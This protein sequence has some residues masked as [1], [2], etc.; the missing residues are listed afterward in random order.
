[1]LQVGA[2]GINQPT[3]Q[4]TNQYPRNAEPLAD[5]AGLLGV[6]DA[7]RQSKEYIFGRTSKFV[8]VHPIKGLLARWSE[9][10]TR[11]REYMSI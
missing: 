11:K 6:W 4:P 8:P 9:I 5:A 1:M 3:N 10:E 2:T 7:S